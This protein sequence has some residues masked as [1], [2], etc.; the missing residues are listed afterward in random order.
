MSDW[1][2]GV[3]PVAGAT[4]DG[5]T[6]DGGARRRRVRHALTAAAIDLFLADGYDETT[7]DGIAAAAG[8]GRRTFFRYF[9]SKEDVIFPDHGQRL[10]M[11]AENLSATEG[12]EAPMPTVCRAAGLVLDAYVDE[13]AI[14]VRR[15]Q[16]TKRIP[17]LRAREIA[18]AHSYQIAFTGYLRQHVGDA[19]SGALWAEVAGAA[20]VA[21]HN[22][23]LRRWLRADGRGDVRAWADHA[24]RVVCD[25]MDPASPAA[26]DAGGDD[27]VIAVLR[28]GTP[29]S[30]VVRRIEDALGGEPMAPSARPDSSSRSQTVEDDRDRP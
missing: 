25:T 15:Y 8:V 4:R 24:F 2:T 28:A 18:S 27:V 12:D 16:L 17:A 5:S 13:G 21:A 10:A 6:R 1:V 19:P 22:H 14:A 11:V 29:L 26:R 9:A 3:P 30:T 20:V 23:V 7:V